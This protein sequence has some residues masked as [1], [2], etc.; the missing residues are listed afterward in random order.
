MEL[1]KIKTKENWQL[2]ATASLRRRGTPLSWSSSTSLTGLKD[3]N[4]VAENLK[5]SY[6]DLT[7]AQIAMGDLAVKKLLCQ[8]QNPLILTWTPECDGRC[9]TC[10]GL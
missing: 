8:L 1:F 7:K 6:D 2:K 10:Y 5:E 4:N 3:P 9:G